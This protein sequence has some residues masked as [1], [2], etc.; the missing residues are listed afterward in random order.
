MDNIIIA[1]KLIK[2][3]NMEALYNTDV[4][5]EQIKY[6]IDCDTD[7][8]TEDGNLL[9]IFRKKALPD[10]HLKSY[11]E[12]LK[13]FTLKTPSNN[14]GSASGGKYK[15]KNVYENKK[16]FSSIMGYFDIWSPSQKK[17]IRELGLNKIPVPEVRP[18]YFNCSQPNKYKN[19]I[20]LIEEINKLYKK[21]LPSYF[22]KQNEKAKETK[23]RVS[24]TAFTTITTNINYK[25]TIHQDK[26]DDDE[27]FGNLVVIEDGEYT[28]G[29]T[30]FPQYG[31]GVDVRQGDILFMDVHQ[32]HGNLPMN[33]KGDGKRMSIVCYLRKKV[34]SRTKDLNE[35]QY[36]NIHNIIK[37]LNPRAV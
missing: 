37:T 25:T 14:R 21:M 11:Y 18:T 8:Y 17:K 9:L 13:Q 6:I 36:E 24:N 33:M 19:A 5:P 12:S 20:P 29:E 23:F 1:E 28:G 34:W 2:D 35:E 31:I 16:I 10:N 27:G 4:K 7:V 3:E 15:C 32:A 30:C 22:Q 26:G